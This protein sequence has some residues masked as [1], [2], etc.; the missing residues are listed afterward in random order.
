MSFAE[1][2]RSRFRF[3]KE[4]PWHF[5]RMVFIYS[6][7]VSACITIPFIIYELFKT[8]SAVFL[9]YGDYN[10]QQIPF[11]RHVVGAVH[12][13][14]FGWDW[15]TDLGSNFIGSYSYYMLGSPFFW[16]M[17]CF[18]ASWVPY[19]MAPMYMVKYIVAALLAY[20]YLQR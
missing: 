15:Y 3:D 20:C 17:A 18:P 10:A 16:L 1:T 4:S 7:I 19:L 2:V 13:G 5:Y 11:Y 6:L 14:N 9:Y 12:E 8:G